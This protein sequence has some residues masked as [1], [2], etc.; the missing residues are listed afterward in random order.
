MHARGFAGSNFLASDGDRHSRS[1]SAH[2]RP[3]ARWHCVQSPGSMLF[4]V[5]DGDRHLPSASR[6]A[7]RK[8]AGIAG[9]IG[10]G[11]VRKTSREHGKC[12]G[13]ARKQSRKRAGSLRAGSAQETLKEH[14]KHSG[15]LCKQNRERTGNFCTGSVQETFPA[16]NVGEHQT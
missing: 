14:R 16:G 8:E 13:N 1:P 15:H 11:S 3:Q 2:P 7:S 4:L 12:S 6:E 9:S 10:A 5:S